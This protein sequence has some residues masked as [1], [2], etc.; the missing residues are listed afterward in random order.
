MT[1]D[2]AKE[3]LIKAGYKKEKHP[4]YDYDEPYYKRITGPDCNCNERPPSMVVT[5]S[6]IELNHEIHLSL[7]INLRAETAA[8]DWAD[9]GWYGMSIDRLDSLSEFEYIIEKMWSSLN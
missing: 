5:I 7:Q 8:G 1:V 2:E 3:L 6:T 9:I 4:F